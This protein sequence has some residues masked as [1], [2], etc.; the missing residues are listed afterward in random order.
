MELIETFTKGLSPS[1][2]CGQIQIL[3]EGVNMTFIL[4]VQ[5]E[6]ESVE[7]ALQKKAEGKTISVNARPQPQPSGVGAIRGSQPQRPTP[8]SPA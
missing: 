4:Q 8:Q 1:S 3:K 7:E 5:V 2:C 6:A